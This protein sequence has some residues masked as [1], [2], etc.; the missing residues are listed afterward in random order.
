VEVDEIKRIV[1]G[2]C[3][4]AVLACKILLA[5]FTPLTI[6]LAYVMSYYSTFPSLPSTYF[7]SLIVGF[8]SIL[9]VDHP[10]L[11]TA[12]NIEVFL[13]SLGMYLL[14]FLMKLPLL[15]IDLLAGVLL[16]RTV[17]KN[18]LDSRR[19]SFAF[20]A[21]YL[22]PYV[23]VNEIWGAL[24]LLPTLLILAA[25]V[26]LREK[27]YVRGSLALLASTTT[28][29]FS[30]LLIP[31]FP[32]LWRRTRQSMLVLFGG[33]VGATIYLLRVIQFGYD[34][35]LFL[36]HPYYEEYLIA[37]LSQ[38]VGM[39]TMA[40]AIA[41]LIV[42]RA[43][44]RDE[45]AMLDSFLVVLLMLFAFMA[46][47]FPQFFVLVIPFLVLDITLQ[48]RSISYLV[49]LT[50]SG[51]V[52][53]VIAFVNYFTANGLAFFFIPVSGNQLL[54]LAMNN[55]VKLATSPFS[56]LVIGQFAQAAFTATCIVY[57]LALVQE[58]TGLLGK[59]VDV[60]HI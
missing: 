7:I 32:A 58:R 3:I 46:N 11:S 28:Q 5:T 44:P 24:D 45:K 50:T 47:W 38:P 18:G 39:A 9:P 41:F 1:E 6:D 59:I 14:V 34:P 48:G 8:W 20:W 40:L 2:S 52:M 31:A 16:Y 57:A 30:V 15:V 25:F 56:V 26:M 54:Q 10:I 33:L 55:Y 22:N 51:L 4:I 60:I 35:S 21:W 43:W 37:P 29:F 12:W 42:W 53:N 13:P 19:A 27:R 49:V 36:S 17:I 23:V